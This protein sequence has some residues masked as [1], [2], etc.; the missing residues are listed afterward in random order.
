MTRSTSPDDMPLIEPT[1]RAAGAGIIGLLATVDPVLAASVAAGAEGA[2]VAVRS[3]ASKLQ[4]VRTQRAIE[5]VKH[6]SRLS[7]LS[8]ED[9]A[10]QV[11]SS[12]K[13]LNATVAAIEASMR[14]S[15]DAKIKAMAKL[16]SEGVAEATDD[17]KLSSIYLK[18]QALS[19]I[20][21]EHLKLLIMISQRIPGVAEELGWKEDRII[22]R[23]PQYETTLPALT[24]TLSSAG[25]IYNNGIGRMSYDQPTWKLTTLGESCLEM[26]KQ[27]ERD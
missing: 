12:D 11:C 20:E 18:I 17:D 27:A 3:V 8:E 14:T 15:L 26:L 1:V 5:S 16:V 10:Q 9:F 21:E 6:A 2:L 13:L 24:A 7:N 4:H 23:L 22:T 25:L 19:R